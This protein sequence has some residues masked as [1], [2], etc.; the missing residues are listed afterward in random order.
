MSFVKVIRYVDGQLA[1]YMEYEHIV[2]ADVLKALR[3]LHS[4]LTEQG[5]RDL[6][7]PEELVI[8][9]LTE[10]QLLYVADTL[11][12][13]TFT[14]PWFMT[15]L[16]ISEEFI[17]PIGPHPASIEQVVEAME[18]LGRANSCTMLSL[19]T[20]ANPRQRGLACLFEKTGA[21][22]STIELVKDITHEQ[23]DQKIN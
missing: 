16:T 20:R 8:T 5:W 1:H 19:G 23:E 3:W 14:E 7:E 4:G 22:L 2:S 11:V 6:R 17:S 18:K 15:T 12:S 13:F 10:T 9:V 21:R